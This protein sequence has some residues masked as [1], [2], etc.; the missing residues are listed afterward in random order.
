[1]KKEIQKVRYLNKIRDSV[2]AAL[3]EKTFFSDYGIMRKHLFDKCSS[4]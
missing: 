3:G 4:K 2:S 1:M